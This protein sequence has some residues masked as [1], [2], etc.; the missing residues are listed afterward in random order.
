MAGVV[1]GLD[2]VDEL[3]SLSLVEHVDHLGRATHPPPEQHLFT[4]SG[5]MKSSGAATKERRQFLR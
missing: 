3:M 4:F 5:P 2:L 1:E